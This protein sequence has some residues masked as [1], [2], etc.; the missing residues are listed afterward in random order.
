MEVILDEEMPKQFIQE[1]LRMTGIP[2]YGSK[3]QLIDRYE[4]SFDVERKKKCTK[5]DLPQL[6][7]MCKVYT[8]CVR[9]ARTKDQFLEVLR[10]V[11]SEC[12]SIYS[13]QMNLNDNF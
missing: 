7:S 2:T 5:P 3:R 9:S 4:L 8:R 11:S 12:V 10:S 1:V 13:Q 6:R